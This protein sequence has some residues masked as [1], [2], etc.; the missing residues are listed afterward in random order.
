MS[1]VLDLCTL[2][3][4]SVPFMESQ[5]PTWEVSGHL[6]LQYVIENTTKLSACACCGIRLRDGAKEINSSTWFTIIVMK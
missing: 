1:G 5:V 6:K 2:S 3:G 4:K